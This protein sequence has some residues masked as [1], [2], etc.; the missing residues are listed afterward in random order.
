METIE[1]YRSELVERI[2]LDYEMPAE[3]GS[4]SM[5]DLIAAALR[6]WY[7]A[8]IIFVGICVIGIPALWLLAEPKYAVT[9]AIR[10]APILSNIVTG[11]AE[12]GEI[13]NYQSFMNTQATMITSPQVIQRVADDLSGKHLAFFEDSAEGIGAKLRRRMEG[14][15]MKPN[16]ANI[17]KQAVYD[18]IITS[19]AER[20]TEL[21]EITMTSDNPE[22]AKKIVDAFIQA[23]M[24]IEVSDSLQGRDQTLTII[25][26][27]R[28]VLGEK[29]NS[30]REAIRQIAQEYGSLSL[31]GRQDMMMRRVSSWLE[32]LTK[33]ES[34][35]I[36][37]ET[38]IQTLEQGQ[39]QGLPEE[40]LNKRNERINSDPTIQELIRNVVRLEQD[41][42]AARQLMTSENPL[43]KQKEEFLDSFKK[44]LEE[45]RQEVGKDFE[46]M[47]AEDINVATKNELLNTRAKLAETLAYENRLRE[48]LTK[49]DT[50]TVELGRKQL[51]IQ[52][53]ED[54]LASMKE[55]YSTY[56]KRIQEL[57]M[58]RK[59]P[60]RIRLAFNADI[61][62]IMDKRI[63]YT[64][65]MVLGALACGVLG[66]LL[67]DKADLSLRT[68]DDVVKRIGIRIIGTTT[69]PQ[70]INKILL[71]KQMTDDYQTIRAN[72]G[73]LDGGGMPKKV[74]I[75]SAGMRDGKTTFAI[76]IA[77]SLSRSGKKVL[78]IDGDMRKP[79]IGR[80]LNVPKE[81]RCLQDAISGKKPIR[82]ALYDATS[83][84]LYVLA[85]NSHS[86]LDPYELLASPQSA[87]CIEEISEDFDNVIID[88][89]PVL[90]FPDALLWAKIAGAVI[91]TGFSGHTTAPDLRDTKQRLAEI[92]VKILGTVLSNVPL[93][94]SYYRY[95]YEYYTRDKHT[96][97]DSRDAVGKP[98][99]LSM[100]NEEKK[101]NDPAS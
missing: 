15:N 20:N 95:G 72:L 90:A 85:A 86:L 5:S 81:S 34:Q 12:R 61:A 78:L 77:T 42:I 7:I 68:P 73:L 58:E 33:V 3:P 65:A 10:V 35:R 14:N 4:A 74:V 93:S 16:P 11:E 36:S 46:A 98:L 45:R 32:E 64:I 53:M 51:A 60:A 17:L 24:L 71:P 92:G 22:E 75:A 50:R 100:D 13:S 59:Q 79:D 39:Q 28:K 67:R 91:L 1:K 2:P 80:I 89:P 87:K 19:K 56:G 9:G 41:L 52:E 82:D 66:A 31:T 63:K 43:L 94:H 49:E 30:Q 6:R 25:E 70:T 57:E 84:G 54:Q 37:Y 47:V 26:N 38:R 88:T 21:V 96:G 76:N 101:P 99:L 23:Y 27:E 83:S 44:R 29:L 69:N 40:L 18:K 62:N 55:L 48:M 8:V 97:R